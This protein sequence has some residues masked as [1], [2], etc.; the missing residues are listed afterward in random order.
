MLDFPALICYRPVLPNGLYIY[1]FF[2]YYVDRKI[3]QLPSRAYWTMKIISL[4]H[5][6]VSTVCTNFPSTNTDFP[7]SCNFCLNIL[8][9]SN[10]H[11]S[12]IPALNCWNLTES[13][14]LFA[15][16]RFW[17]HNYLINRKWFNCLLWTDA[18]T[19]AHLI[20]FDSAIEYFQP[21]LLFAEAFHERKSF[22]LF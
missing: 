20:V 4:K 7:M 14:F 21:F 9:T 13:L 11:W 1:M 17:W 8:T 16:F 10:R 15:T 18:N 3:R 22:F 5:F 19:S 2:F 12:P 6:S